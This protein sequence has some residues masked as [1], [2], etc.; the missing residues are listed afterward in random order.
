MNAP[1]TRILG[2]TDAAGISDAFEAR[3]DINVITV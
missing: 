1:L 2:K 3:S